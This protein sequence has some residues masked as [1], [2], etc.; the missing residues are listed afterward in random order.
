[1]TSTLPNCQPWCRRRC[2]AS[3]ARVDKVTCTTE[4]WYVHLPRY[5]FPKA[6]KSYLLTNGSD[7]KIKRRD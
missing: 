2:A 3:E 5:A 6:N 1:V 7:G 4:R